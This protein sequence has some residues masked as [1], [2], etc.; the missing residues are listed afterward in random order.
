MRIAAS[1]LLIGLVLCGCQSLSKLDSGNFDDFL[2]RAS[3][4]QKQ[5]GDFGAFFVQQVSRFGGHAVGS[6]SAPA[7][8]GTW[9]SESDHNGFAAQL[10]GVPFAEVQ[11]F[12]EAVYGPPLDLSTNADSPPHGLYGVRQI[13]VGIQYFGV[14]NGVGFI[15]VEKLK[16]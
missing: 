16:R 8:S 11:S 12:M 7:L 13:G 14:T 3:H 6:S 4:S 10:Y 2:L 1:L 9:Y 15:C 5:L